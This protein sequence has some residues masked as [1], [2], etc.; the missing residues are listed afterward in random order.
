MSLAQ[1]PRFLNSVSFALFAFSQLLH[2]SIALAQGMAQGSPPP[3][4]AK[5]IKCKNRQ[6]PQ[7]EDVTQKSG[8]HFSHTSAPEARYIVESMSGG[9]LL[10]DYDRDGWLDIYFTNAPTVALALHGET[11][12]G[13]LYH[14]NHDGTFTDVT[15]KAGFLES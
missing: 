8:V 5:T 12:N 3:A 9:V 7:L 10:L 15:D 11:V 6:I 4:G 1:R 13:A 14:N 2:S